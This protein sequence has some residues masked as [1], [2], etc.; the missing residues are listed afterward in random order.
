MA[1][2]LEGGGMMKSKIKKI[3]Y[4]VAAM[5]MMAPLAALAQFD[6][7]LGDANTGLSN[8]SITQI[9]TV[10]MKWLLALV[11]VFGVIGFAVAGVL[12]LTAA[13]NEG[14]IDKAKSAMMYSILG[15]IVALVGLVVVNAVSRW[16]GGTTGF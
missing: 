12:Y 13:G 2:L 7:A 8:T 10:F 3:S 5:G 14:Q 16:L 15:V 1:I 6:P 11:G 4:A 9:V